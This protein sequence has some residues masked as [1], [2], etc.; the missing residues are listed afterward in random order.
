[1]ATYTRETTITFTQAF[2]DS[3]GDPIPPIDASYPQVQVEAPT[4]TIVASG[5]AVSTTPGTWQWSWTSSAT[6]VLGDGWRIRWNLVDPSLSA[7]EA[8]TA[9]TLSDQVQQPTGLDR[10]GAYLVAVAQSERLIWK[11]DVDPQVVELTLRSPSVTIATW[12]KGVPTPPATAL[13]YVYD[14]GLHTYYAD[15]PVFVTA[16]DYL[17]FWRTRSNTASPYVSESQIVHVPH[18][19]FWFMVPYLRQ[20]L[21]KLGKVQTSPLSYLDIELYQAMNQGMGFVN[22]VYPFTDFGWTNYPEGFRSWLILAAGIWA[23]NARQMLEI[24]VSHSA[25]ALS[26]SLEYDHASPLADVISRWET[27]LREWLPVQKLGAYRATAGPGCVG[28]RPLR[29]SWQSR[30]FRIGSSNTPIGDFPQ[31]MTALGLT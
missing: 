14:A 4:G 1:M 16:G 24:E 31:L 30:V 7:H 13:S 28:V 9:F 8:V 27:M 2:L 6:A 20:L 21:D 17:S 18:D 19:S 3:V 11:G 23:L 15:T 12:A 22:A 26:V 10:L 29:L 25:Q 5:I